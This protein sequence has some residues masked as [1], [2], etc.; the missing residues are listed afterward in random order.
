MPER[1]PEAPPEGASAFRWSAGGALGL[2]ALILLSGPLSGGSDLT[3]HLRLM[4]QM[5][6]APALR[7]V[8]APAFH[9]AGALLGSRIGWDLAAE[10]LALASAAALLFGFRHWQRAA[11]L[12]DACASLFAWAPY[13]FALSWCLPKVE[14]AGYGLAFFALAW[15]WQGRHLRLAVALAATFWVHTGAALFLGLAG[16][17]A[18]LARRDRRALGALAFGSALA[19]PLWAAHVVAGCSWA[20]ALLLSA[21]DYLRSTEGWS[22]LDALPRIAVLAGPVAVACALPGA[23]E[24]WHRERTVAWLC[25]AILALW[26]NELW[27]APFGARTTLNLLRGLTLLAVPVACAAG[28]FIANRPRV[29]PALWVAVVLWALGSTWLALP[30]SCQR[31]PVDWERVAH[32]HVDR[33]TFRWAISEAR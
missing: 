6:D 24:L 5:A 28:V 4:Q 2:H 23:R 18:A 27:L 9:A 20:Q 11:Q 32:T 15:L 22:S 17:I 14:A 26:S 3:P 21:G 25:I 13:G 1:M 30:G 33:C 31:V 8:Y 19:A 29:A 10:L 7:N 12:P 16:G